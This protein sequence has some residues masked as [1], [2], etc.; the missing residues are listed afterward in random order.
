MST[1]SIIVP[2]YNSEKFLSK[3]V[4]SLL[5]QSLPDF[6]IL[7]INDGSNDGSLALC[8][9]YAQTDSRIK[10]YDKPN[11][12]VSSARNYG[13]EHATGEYIMFVDSDDWLAPDALALCMPYLPEYDIVRFSAVDVSEKGLKRHKLG[14][15]SDKQKVLSTIMAR[16][17]IVACY[18]SAI[19]RSLFIDNNIRFDKNIIIGEDWL[20]TAQL[21]KACRN[22]KLLPDA[23]CY[24][25]NR[26]NAD[27]CTMT[28][29]SGKLMQQLVVCK[30]IH[31]L[32]NSTFTTQ[33]RYSLCVLICELIDNLGVSEAGRCLR[34][35]DEDFDVVGLFD[36]LTAN[37]SL[38]KRTLLLRFWLAGYLNINR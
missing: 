26:C 6:E 32:L 34:E 36:I 13:I 1:F 12:G 17:T 11:G 19:R 27:S 24:F 2:I 23:Y 14:K 35:S 30:I 7:L 16:R 29:N 8:N 25:Y 10:V 38:R 9:N 31:K 20:V 15:N 22:I 18:C 37:I 3:C 5:A 21:V 33:Y 28:L 4:D